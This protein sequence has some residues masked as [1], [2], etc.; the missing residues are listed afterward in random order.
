[1]N[2]DVAEGL[3]QWRATENQTTEPELEC[4]RLPTM[5]TPSV[6]F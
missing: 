3:G 1:M 5:Y 6:N 2:E 4:R